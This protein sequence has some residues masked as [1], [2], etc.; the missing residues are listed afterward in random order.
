MARR[1]FYCYDSFYHDDNLKV[2]HSGSGLV[3]FIRSSSPVGFVFFQPIYVTW[4]K[5]FFM[6]S[7]FKTHVPY[8]STHQTDFSSNISSAEDQHL[9]QAVTCSTPTTSCVVGDSAWYPDSGATAHLNNDP[10]SFRVV[11]HTVVLVK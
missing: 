11:T 7:R 3:H 1:C 8:S 10:L 6:S 5:A 2:S 9:M 4:I